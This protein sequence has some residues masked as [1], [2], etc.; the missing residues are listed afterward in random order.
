M[1]DSAARAPSEM[2]VIEQCEEANSGVHRAQETRRREVNYRDTARSSLSFY[3]QAAILDRM[4]HDVWEFEFFHH[5]VPTSA[6]KGE[7]YT[8]IQQVC[9]DPLA[10]FIMQ[11]ETWSR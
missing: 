2:L 5:R 8:G 6:V 9:S 4:H 1:R 7:G 10:R 3:Q 11:P